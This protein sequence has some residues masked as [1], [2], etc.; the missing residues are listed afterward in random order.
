MDGFLNGNHIPKLNQEQVN[1]LNR[2]ISHKE[3]EVI[4]N[5]PKQKQTNK[6]QGQ[7]YLVQNSIRIP[8]I[9]TSFLKLGSTVHIEYNHDTVAVGSTHFYMQM[10]KTT[11]TIL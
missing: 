7:M 9:V 5:L 4:K 10:E 8:S 3:I 11:K 1:Y 2:P 6:K